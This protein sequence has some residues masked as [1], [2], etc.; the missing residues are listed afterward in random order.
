MRSVLLLAGLCGVLAGCN[1]GANEGASSTPAR[2]GHG[3]YTGQSVHY[4][5]FGY[6]TCRKQTMHYLA[7]GKDP[8]SLTFMTLAPDRYKR[9]AEAGCDA[10]K[11]SAASLGT[12]TSGQTS[13]QGTTSELDCTYSGTSEP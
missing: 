3:G 11:A 4:Y 9:A 2:A 12:C 8:D 13:D 6:K 10:G 1:L 5:D 7:T